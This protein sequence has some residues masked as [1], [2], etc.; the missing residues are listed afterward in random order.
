MDSSTFDSSATPTPSKASKGKGKR[1][2]SLSPDQDEES[3]TTQLTPAVITSPDALTA[4]TELRNDF[5]ALMGVAERLDST[6][7][8]QAEALADARDLIET[9]MPIMEVIATKDNAAFSSLKPTIITNIQTYKTRFAALRTSYQ[10]TASRRENAEDQLD[11]IHPNAYTWVTDH[12]GSPNYDPPTALQV[13]QTPPEDVLHWQRE[14]QNSKKDP[15]GDE[16][17]QQAEDV[18][19]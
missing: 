12:Q 16:A 3:N 1:I 10:T 2:R 13:F 7:M 11:K 18:I 17:G 5:V 15:R 4:L 19:L 14:F 9:L 8:T 6:I